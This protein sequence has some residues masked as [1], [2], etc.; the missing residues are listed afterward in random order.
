VNTS[1]AKAKS[2]EEFPAGSD[3]IDVEAHA[4]AGREV[5]PGKR[6]RIRI[7]KQHFDVEVSG[8]TGR[9]LLALAGKTPPERFRIDQ[10][11]RG[12]QT[13]QIGL[14]ERADFTTPG[15]ERYMTLP[16]DQTEG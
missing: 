2:P 16:L 9:E 13:R 14:D 1:T 7:D 5:P 6:Y 4:T 10:K 15:L 11:L 8:M 3:I 12:G